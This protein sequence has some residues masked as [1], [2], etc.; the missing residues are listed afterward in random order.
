MELSGPVQFDLDGSRLVGLE[1]L[2]DLGGERLGVQEFVAAVP[3]YFGLLPPRLEM[4]DLSGRD[5][6]LAG[7]RKTERSA[8]GRGC[9]GKLEDLPPGNAFSIFYF[10]HELMLD[11]PHPLVNPA[12]FSTKGAKRRRPRERLL[13]ICRSLDGLVSPGGGVKNNEEP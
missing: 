5:S 1:M 3:F 11:P 6:G 2:H 9:P 8:E 10:F 7:V 4:F 12:Q 13:D